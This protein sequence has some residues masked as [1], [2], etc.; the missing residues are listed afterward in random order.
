MPSIQRMASPSGSR[1][2]HS[3]NS[4]F[5]FG[6]KSLVDSFVE[7][8]SST[9]SNARSFALDPNRS[10]LPVS[11]LRSSP[12]I[13][14]KAKLST[15]HPLA[16]DHSDI[17][18]DAREGDEDEEEHE[19]TVIDRMRLWRHDA[20]MQHLY[21][22]AAFWGDKVVSWTSKFCSYVFTKSISYACAPDD[23]ND[24]FWLAQTYFLTHQYSR[25]ERLLTRPFPASVPRD[26]PTAPSLTN[27]HFGAPSL[28]ELKGKGKDTT[29]GRGTTGLPPHMNPRLPMGP[30]EMIDVAVEYD[31]AVSR[32]VDMS[33]ACRYLAA[34]CQV[35]QGKWA[36]ATEM[37]GEANPFRGS[38]QS[39]PNIPNT[40]GGIKVCSFFFF[41]FSRSA[42][43]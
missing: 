25:A 4:S 11:P 31:D 33:V 42:K 24:A 18:H 17:F 37:L 36:E 5:S 39:G 10:I 22:T 29:S 43:S 1:S 12:Q 3:I 9:A 34:Q 38:G 2:R 35:R 8:N 30:S 19:W 16:N 41:F 21:E 7:A 26:P 28:A 23:P 6:P 14:R 32:L 13:P 27:G 15:R 40:D 20:L